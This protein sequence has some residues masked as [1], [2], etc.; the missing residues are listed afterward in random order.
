MCFERE[1]E[2]RERVSTLE[3]PCWPA[4]C[5]GILLAAV[6]ERQQMLMVGPGGKRGVAGPASR[7]RRAG[8]R[9]RE[10]AAAAGAR[11]AKLFLLRTGDWWREASMSERSQ[12]KVAK[13]GTIGRSGTCVPLPSHYH[14]KKILVAHAC[15]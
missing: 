12:E 9:E 14:L 1:R 13:S 15:M 11:R 5:I 4:T 8:R 10:S 7:T 3:A 2:L 6:D